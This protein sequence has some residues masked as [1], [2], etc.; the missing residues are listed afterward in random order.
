[1]QSRRLVPPYCQCNPLRTTELYDPTTGTWE[2]GPEL[3]HP[4]GYWNIIQLADGKLLAAGTLAYADGPP[5]AESQLFDPTTSTW[6]V[7]GSMNSRRVNQSMVLLETGEVLA[8]GGMENWAWI[9][10]SN[11]AELYD[12]AERRWRTT[13]KP[14]ELRFR[15][16]LIRLPDGRVLRAGACGDSDW[17]CRS[18]PSAQAW[19]YD[20]STETWRETTP[21]HYPH[22][23]P[24][25]VLLDSG[26][27][28]VAG[29]NWAN[30]TSAEW[31][32]GYY[33][34]PTPEIFD[35]RTETWWTTDLMPHYVMGGGKMVKLP[36]GAALFTGGY[37]NGYGN[38]DWVAISSVQVY[39]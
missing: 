32:L 6:E 12:P 33:P 36:S 21:M 18:P 22:N 34:S 20:R 14:P 1:M 37:V 27:V 39:Q 11:A 23:F 19:I 35:P 16:V 8:V 15:E 4:P 10:I 13:A 28:L 26:Q 2:P 38:F 25:S 31:S 9:N 3:L 17:F 7:V 30:S 5:G 24:S 29:G